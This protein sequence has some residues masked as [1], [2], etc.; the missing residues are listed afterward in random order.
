MDNYRRST[1]E[2]TVDGLRPALAAAIRAHAE[3]RGMADALSSPLLCC[4]TT[5][6]RK[7]RG[8]FRSKEEVFLLGAVLTAEWLIWATGKEGERPAVIAARLRDI[9]VE[10]Y[11]TSTR[12]S[13]EDRGVSIFGLHT[14][15]GF[16]S[17]FIGLG[18]EPAARLFRERLKDAVARA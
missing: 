5:S 16:G 3:K 15:E 17:A 2:C 1:R 10:D 13:Q 14:G 12:A 11:E 6:T 4:E 9:R 8:L 7:K 18:P